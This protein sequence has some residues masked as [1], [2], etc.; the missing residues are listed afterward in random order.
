[1]ITD[2]K[3]S[4]MTAAI[5]VAKSLPLSIVFVFVGDLEQEQ[6]MD[7]YQKYQEQNP[8]VGFINFSNPDAKII[9]QQYAQIMQEHC[10]E[11]E[12]RMC[13]F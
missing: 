9:A 12:N 6:D 5:Q 10:V 8:L 4:D 2:G 3:L 7:M 11:R 13:V 1:M